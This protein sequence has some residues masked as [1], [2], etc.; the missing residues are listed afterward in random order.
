MSDTGFSAS[1]LI[2]DANNISRHDTQNKAGDD[3]Q[4]PNNLAFKIL[5]MVATSRMDLKHWD[6]TKGEKWKEHVKVT[7]R[8]FE[9]SNVTVSLIR[10]YVYE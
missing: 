6:N 10:L 9:N 4:D 2:V 7:V 5:C 8:R 3:S 1:R